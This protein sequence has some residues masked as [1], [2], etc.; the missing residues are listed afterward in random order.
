MAGASAGEVGEGVRGY[1]GQSGLVA[2]LGPIELE[3]R[4]VAIGAHAIGRGRPACIDG[5]LTRN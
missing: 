5:A 2:G 4:G 1:E 3:R